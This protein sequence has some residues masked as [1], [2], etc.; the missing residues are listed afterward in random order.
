[1]A[2]QKTTLSLPD[3]SFVALNAMSKVTFDEKKWKQQRRVELDGEAFF[4]VAPGSRFDV[5]T[6]MGTISVLGTAFNVRNRQDYFE[7]ICYE[8]SVEVKSEEVVRLSP[9]QIFRLVNGVV[10]K[11]EAASQSLPDWRNG[12]SSFRSV[13][14]RYVLEEFERQFNVSVTT[15]NVDRQRIFTGTFTHSDFSVALKSIALP[16]NLAYEVDGKKIILTG[17]N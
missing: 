9:H 8:G 3:S 17:E 16:F 15:V 1:M 7:V 2:A 11:G 6:S 10:T 14:F 4:K 12:E 5:V 13:P